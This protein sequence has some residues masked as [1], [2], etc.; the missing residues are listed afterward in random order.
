MLRSGSIPCGWS[1]GEGQVTRGLERRQ[2]EPLPQLRV[3]E[4]AF[5]KGSFHNTASTRNRRIIFAI[6]EVKKEFRF[7]VTHRTGFRQCLSRQFRPESLRFS[8]IL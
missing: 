7:K 2:A 4:K 5:R 6:F 1:F 8:A 3:D